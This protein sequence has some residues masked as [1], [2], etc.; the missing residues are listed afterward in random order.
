MI[1]ITNLNIWCLIIKYNSSNTFIS[2]IDIKVQHVNHTGF[3]KKT[4]IR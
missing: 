3:F 1:N 2:R 4:A